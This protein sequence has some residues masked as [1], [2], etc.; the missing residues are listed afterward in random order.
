MRTVHMECLPGIRM[1]IT[2]EPMEFLRRVEKIARSNQALEVKSNY[3]G[4]GELSCNVVSF[5]ERAE[6]EHQG[7]FAMF[8]F[9]K[10]HERDLQLQVAAHRWNP[11]PPT[12]DAYVAASKRLFDPIIRA[13]NIKFG[14]RHR[15]RIETREDLLPK[16]T[17]K[18]QEAFNY[19]ARTSN[20]ESLHPLDWEKFYRF[21]YVSYRTGRHL[22]TDEIRWFCLGAGFSPTQSESLASAFHHCHNFHKSI[23][24]RSF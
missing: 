12:Y 22:S 13:Y 5:A 3:E 20:L 17:P 2:I 9:W 7:L 8:V 11:D 1:R 19:F 14:V 21:V 4:D 23:K 16:M 15:M 18:Q 24:K 10:R 6:S